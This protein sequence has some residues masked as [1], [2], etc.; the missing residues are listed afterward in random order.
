[1]KQ[2]L[3]LLVF[4]TF[5]FSTVL[6]QAPGNGLPWDVVYKMTKEEVRTIKGEKGKVLLITFIRQRGEKT[7]FSGAEL[8]LSKTDAQT[9]NKL[10]FE[11]MMN[12]N[13]DLHYVIKEGDEL[14]IRSRGDVAIYISGYKY[15]VQ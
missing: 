11:I 12:I 2:L 9:G 13:A 15:D 10:D 4:F 5:S 1:M 7:I 8:T 3:T 6:A 14:N